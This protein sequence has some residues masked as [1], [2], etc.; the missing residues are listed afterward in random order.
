VSSGTQG[1]QSRVARDHVTLERFVG[2]TRTQIDLLLEPWDEAQVCNLGPDTGE[3][4][5]LWFAYVM[6]I[7]DLILPSTHYVHGDVFYPASV[8]ADL[9]S[10]AADTQPIIVGPPVLFLHLLD[11]MERRDIR[12]RLGACNGLIVTAGGWKRFN[13]EAIARHVLT[14]RLVDRFGVAGP[15][16]VRDA[17]NMVE[18]NTVM[19]ECENHRKHIPPWLVVLVRDPGT[20]EPVCDGAPGLISYLDPTANSYPGFILSD[21]FG[22]ASQEPCAC[23]RTGPT[24]EIVRRVRRIESRGCALKMDR[25][26][27]VSEASV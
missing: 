5:D 2:S 27:R 22:R 7:L 14:E 19:L 24:L 9:Q 13:D 17:F 25:S 12:L 3:A 18:L 15:P 23:N 4:N 11:F 8:I 26:I 21:D 10:L 6:S 20:L 1:S 16:Q